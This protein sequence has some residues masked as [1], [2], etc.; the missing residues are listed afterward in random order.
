MASTAA[1]IE[2]NACVP[3]LIYRL[4]TANEYKSYETQNRVM[5]NDRE[6]R[7][8]YML[9]HTAPQ[10]MVAAGTQFK[11]QDMY[12]VQ[13]NVVK[14]GGG[15]RWERIEH[16]DHTDLEPRYYPFR[17]EGIHV[18]FEAVKSCVRVLWDGHSCH[19]FPP[20]LL[21]TPL[22]NTITEVPAIQPPR[23]AH[24]YRLCPETWYPLFEQTKRLTGSDNE[25][26]EGRLLFFTAPQAAIAASTLFPECKDLCAVKVSVDKL[27]SGLRWEYENNEIIPRYYPTATSKSSDSVYAPFDAITECI[28]IPWDDRTKSFTFPSAINNLPSATTATSP[29]PATVPMA[30]SPAAAAEPRTVQRPRSTP[31]FVYRLC[32]D[33]QFRE[34]HKLKKILPNDREIIEGCLAL[35]TPAQA[36]A[37][38]ATQYKGLKDLCVL[39]INVEKLGDGLRWEISNNEI[40]PRYY[41]KRGESVSIPF[42]IDVVGEC[43]SLPWDKEK[44]SHIFPS[45]IVAENSG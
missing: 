24:V 10:A 45:S 29:P 19:I 11:D 17:S 2:P 6:I 44:S 32:T 28:R 30:A 20:A 13:L 34:S 25:V 1:D 41:P 15:L 16:T 7:E 37:T 33:E 21:S 35:C 18:P 38:A 31:A 23:P 40:V 26:G 43:V 12:A 5:P 4:C 36:I 27:G 42:A 8:G 3:G 14:L 39:K 22:L 9:L